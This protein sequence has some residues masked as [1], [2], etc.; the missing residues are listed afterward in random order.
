M[1]LIHD[2]DNSEACCD[3]G[4]EASEGCVGRLAWVI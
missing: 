1:Y 4:S 3:E 2:V